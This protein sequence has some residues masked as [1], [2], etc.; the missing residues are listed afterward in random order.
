MEKFKHEIYDRVVKQMN[1]NKLA[2]LKNKTFS[3]QQHVH[4]IGMKHNCMSH[5]IWISTT[6]RTRPW[7][8]MFAKWSISPVYTLPCTLVITFA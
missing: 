7:A 8:S 4:C 5:D 1:I 2:P 3:N 6:S